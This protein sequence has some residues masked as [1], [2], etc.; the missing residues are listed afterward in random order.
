MSTQ[1]RVLVALAFALAQSL[2]FGES[3]PF[4]GGP[5]MPIAASPSP[6]QAPQGT[7]GAPSTPRPQGPAPAA[8]PAAGS[9]TAWPSADPKGLPPVASDTGLFV[10]VITHGKAVRKAFVGPPKSFDAGRWLVAGDSIPG[11]QSGS[12]AAVCNEGLALS[13]GE[14]ISVGK[15]IPLEGPNDARRRVRKGE[16][17]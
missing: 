1:N 12:V 6:L 13:T 16:P 11:R 17:C 5:S 7:L 2:S 4:S 3:G 14:F 10:M 9:P 8:L 15:A